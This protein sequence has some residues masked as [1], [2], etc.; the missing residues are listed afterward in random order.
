M[1][2]NGAL[3]FIYVI[4]WCWVRMPTNAPKGKSRSYTELG[5][6]LGISRI[7]HF[8]FEK[9]LSSKDRKICWTL[10]R[11]AN[12]FAMLWPDIHIWS[13]KAETCSISQWNEHTFFWK[14]TLCLS[15][16]LSPFP[17][18]SLHRHTSP[19]FSDE[20]R[21]SPGWHSTHNPVSASQVLGLQG[22]TNPSASKRYMYKVIFC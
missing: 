5:E 19:G 17:F 14:T 11:A 15:A 6:K 12:A 9:M 2:V 16:C 4:V 3:T 18:L 1:M 21:C 7:F 20:I 8:Y 10:L 13:K 22:W